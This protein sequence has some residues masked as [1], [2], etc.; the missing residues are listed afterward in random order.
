MITAVQKGYTVK[1][2]QKLKE[3]DPHQL[4]NGDLIMREASPSYGHQGILRDVFYQIMNHLKNNPAGETLCAPIDIYLDEENVL[5]PDIVF[6]S[7]ERSAITENDGFHGA[8]DMVIEI[9]S[10]STAHYDNNVK[11]DL[12][13]KHGVKEFWVIDPEDKSVNGF[14]NVDGTFCEFFTGKN[15]FFSKLLNLEISLELGK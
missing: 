6:V 13:E 9:L 2:Y 3:G 11:K 8:P 15:V 4:I 5:Q 12:Y 7:N 1:D 14:E 10:P